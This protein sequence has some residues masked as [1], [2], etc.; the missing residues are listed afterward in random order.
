MNNINP[1]ELIL[2]T[3]LALEKDKLEKSKKILK[4][5]ASATVGMGIIKTIP[6]VVPL[7]KTA[8]AST[9]AFL[10]GSS[11]NFLGCLAIPNYFALLGAAAIGTE[12]FTSLKPLMNNLENKWHNKDIKLK[13]FDNPATKL[14]VGYDREYNEI[15]VDMKKTPNI[16]IMGS[17]NMGKTKCVE[18]MLNSLKGTKITLINTF[19]DDFTSLPDV[20]RINNFDEIKV[21]LKSVLDNKTKREVPEY[22]VIDECNVLSLEKD[23]DRLIKGLL[24]QCRHYN[25]YLICILQLANKN[26][27]PYKN[28]FGTRIS[29][30]HL[31]DD[32]ITTF[33]G[34]KPEKIL[35]PREFFMYDL[36]YKQGFT[37][38]I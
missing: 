12:V 33:L 24:A 6:Y 19:E 28:L 17:P 25:V 20:K 26:D 34:A 37:Y 16:G 29:F 31:D 3:Q 7:T 22:I 27:C 4:I 9:T 30:R 2:N 5:T 1:E 38:T 35:E 32:L 23:I 14:V 21:Y 18:A 8:F 15:V 10:G 11:I 13:E 36:D